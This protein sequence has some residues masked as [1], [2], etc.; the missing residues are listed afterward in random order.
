MEFKKANAE[1]TGGNIYVYY[2]QLEDGRYFLADDDGE[3]MLTYTDPVPCFEDAMYWEWQCEHGIPVTKEQDDNA[4]EGQVWW[5]LKADD[6]NAMLDWIIENR[7]EG[8][9]S[10]S[11][12]KARKEC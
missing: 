9:Y 4:E 8:N 7:P 6:W 12:L 1:Y 3:M 10:V 11:E 2:G 5:T